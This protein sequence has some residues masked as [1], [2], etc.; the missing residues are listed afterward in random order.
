MLVLYCTVHQSASRFYQTTSQTIF[1][2]AAPHFANGGGL[3]GLNFPSQNPKCKVF[4][5][6]T[7][8]SCDKDTDRPC[9]IKI[10][11]AYSTNQPTNQPTNRWHLYSTCDVANNN[12]IVIKYI[13]CHQLQ[14]SFIHQ[15]FTRTF[16]YSANAANIRANDCHEYFS[17]HQCECTGKNHCTNICVKVKWP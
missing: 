11:I 9:Y 6:L 14:I 3:R 16:I 13:Y 15:L 1:W 12:Q 7:V 17:F 10:Y 5:G 2:S 8:M 4:A